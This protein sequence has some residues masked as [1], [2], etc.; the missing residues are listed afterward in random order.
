MKTKVSKS[1]TKPRIKEIK[2]NKNNAARVLLVVAMLLMSFNAFQISAMKDMGSMS[3]GTS[4]SGSSTIA[5]QA[6]SDIIPTGVPKVWGKELDFSYDDIDPYDPASANAA[7]SMLGNLD[8]TIT[9][10]SDLV[11][12]YV[13]I[14][15]KSN[16]GMSCEF[17]CGAK[18]IIFENGSPAC[19]CAHSFAMRG[20]TK[21]LLINHP[22]M[23]DEDILTDVGKLKVLFFPGI[24]ESKAAAME[25]KGID[26][27]I[28]ALTTNENR[29][30]EKGQTSGGSMVGGC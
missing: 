13:Q 26:V 3:M 20:I 14:L 10:P 16:G 18:S 2:I 4:S 9:L 15:F 1:G 21:Y 29:G 23:S 5:K 8:R 30:I 11:E 22:D 6:K 17:C 28:I 19:G 12:R 27:N 24:H 25:A 7:I